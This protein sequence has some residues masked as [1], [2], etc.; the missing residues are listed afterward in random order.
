[1]A[2]SFSLAA[3]RVVDRFYRIFP[4]ES[5]TKVDITSVKSRW[6]AR[7]NAH[8]MRERLGKRDVTEVA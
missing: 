8:I 7:K 3:A 1:M 4:D 6:Y 5:V 2:P